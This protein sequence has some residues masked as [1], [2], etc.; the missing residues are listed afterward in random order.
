MG[1]SQRLDGGAM[2][3]NAPK[4]MWSKWEKSDQNNQIYL[5]TRCMLVELDSTYY[6]FEAGVGNFFPPNMASRYGVIENNSVLVDSLTGHGI[7]P[8]QISHVIMSHLHFDHVGGLLTPYSDENKYELIFK[9]A[10]FYTS[11]LA[12]ERALKPH[13]RD[14]ASFI[15]ELQ[16][17]LQESGRLKFLKGLNGHKDLPTSFQF[18]YYHGHTPGLV[19]SSVNF[20]TNTFPQAKIYFA[21]DLIP[22]KSWTNNSITMGYDRYPELAIDE[23]EE[24]LEL[25][26]KEGS[27]LFYTH[28]PDTALASVK[29]NDRGRFG[30]NETWSELTGVG[31]LASK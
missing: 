18:R 12:W 29:I 5:S 15:P 1:N 22:G 19:V 8:D 21:T 28:D 13:K 20:P 24:L 6:L 17:L 9:N 7:N 27:F 31:T 4:A 23:K 3:G 10:S 16:K 25:I 14:R 30:P 11:T 26:H 2:F